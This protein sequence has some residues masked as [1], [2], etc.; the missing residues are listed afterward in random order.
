MFDE[1]A[2][3]DHLLHPV[4]AKHFFAEFYERQPLLICR[5]DPDYYAPV[6]GLSDIDQLLRSPGTPSKFLRVHKEGTEVLPHLW[7][8]GSEIEVDGLSMLIAQ[9]ATII[10]NSA[11]R[12]FRPLADFCNTVEKRVGFAV[13]PNI[14]ITPACAQGF[15]Q[16]YDDH[17]V[18][19]MQVH[20]H[21]SWRLY[22]SPIELPSKSHQHE[23]GKYT[24]RA[25]EHTFDLSEGDVLYIPRG[26]LHDAETSDVASIHVT[27]GLHPTYLWE[28][29]EQIAR[30][31]RDKPG[32][33][34][35]VHNL[36]ADRPSNEVFARM[37]QMI[38]D[39]VEETD[40]AE[41]LESLNKWHVVHRNPG[42]GVPF[43]DLLALPNVNEDSWVKSVD[44][45][46]YR[47]EHDEGQIHLRLAGP[48][49]SFPSFLEEPLH[50][51]LEST[52]QRVGD[53]PGLLDADGRVALARQ[54]IAAGV[55]RTVPPPKKTVSSSNPVSAEIP[56]ELVP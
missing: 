45:L 35:A 47:I 48:D 13:Q 37:K 28:V 27:L 25:V 52:A 39:L 30:K 31:A 44:N 33:R 9:G 24:D 2:G 55:V 16:H 23:W 53:I 22:G 12:F 51:L 42:R 4:N 20:G 6:L 19:I 17:D 29:V 49:L 34:R 41:I 56:E 50:A 40:I 1:R 3:F 8:R 15:R 11:N 7:S 5:D 10:I 21:K 18:F 38:H 36:T 32:F 26:H 43:T 54:L 46:V 14:Y